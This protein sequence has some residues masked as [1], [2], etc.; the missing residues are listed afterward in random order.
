MMKGLVFT[1]LLVALMALGSNAQKAEQQKWS[2]YWEASGKSTKIADVY[3]QGQDLRV[4][5]RLRFE[6]QFGK[7]MQT[8]Q[9]AWFVDFFRSGEARGIYVPPQMSP[10]SK[11]PGFI[12]IKSF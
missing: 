2:V 8:G 10:I 7:D 5:T 1:V 4:E 12:T 3:W 11:E 9:V 6:K